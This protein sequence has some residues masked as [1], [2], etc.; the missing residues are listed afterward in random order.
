MPH[1]HDILAVEGDLLNAISWVSSSIAGH[2]G[3]ISILTRSS[4]GLW[5]IQVE[6]KHVGQSANVMAGS[7]AKQG[8][9]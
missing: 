1:F 5:C 8:V 4:P 9:D 3:F 7:S 2:G 6:F